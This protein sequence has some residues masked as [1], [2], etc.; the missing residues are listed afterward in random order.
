MTTPPVTLERLRAAQQVIAARLMDNLD[1]AD[2][3][4]RIEAEIAAA[5]AMED[6]NPVTRAR[7]TIEARRTLE[8][9]MNAKEAA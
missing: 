6:P 2:A 1:Y 7:R 5:E 8:G 3:F 4:E 9:F